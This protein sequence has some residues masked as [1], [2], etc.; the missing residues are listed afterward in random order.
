MR[1]HRGKK[2][3]YTLYVFYFLSFVKTYNTTTNKQGDNNCIVVNAIIIV[4]KR[5]YCLFL[6]SLFVNTK[7]DVWTY[8]IFYWFAVTALFQ[9]IFWQTQENMEL[10]KRVN[11]K[12]WSKITTEMFYETSTQ[13]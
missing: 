2:V 10:L 3:L 1:F 8:Y 5:S 4:Q 13:K 12:E 6:P 11:L 9:Y 7:D